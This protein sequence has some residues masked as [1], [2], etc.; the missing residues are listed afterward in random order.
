MHTDHLISARG[1]DL[2][3]I[4]RKKKDLQNCRLA[5]QA[6]HRIK[7]KEC[8]NKDKYLDFARE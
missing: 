5:I 8:A 7:L 3:I 6:D 2:I 4:N 1:L